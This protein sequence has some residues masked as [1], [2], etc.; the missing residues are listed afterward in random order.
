MGQIKTQAE[1]D[2]KTLNDLLKNEAEA[3]CL[4][5]DASV[6]LQQLVEADWKNMSDPAIKPLITTDWT[7]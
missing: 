7:E 2:G 6:Q 1:T 4:M 3:D 5:D